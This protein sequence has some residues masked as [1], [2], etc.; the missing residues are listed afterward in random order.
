MRFALWVV[1][2]SMGVV[3]C[4]ESGGPPIQIGIA[5][6]WED[7]EGVRM[8]VDEINAAGGVAHRMIQLE[9][10]DWRQDGVFPPNE[11]IEWAYRFADLPGLVAV[12]GHSDSASTLLSASIYN[13]RQVPQITTIA[14]N[15]A[16]T[17]I[18][19]W[20]FRLCAS[21]RT[22][23]RALAEYAIQGWGKRRIAVIAVDDD[24]GQGLLREFSL[25]VAEL[26]G[27][28]VGRVLHPNEELARS[29]SERERI[30]GV[31]RDLPT[32]ADLLLLIERYP[33]AGQTLRLMAEEGVA[34]DVLGSDSV[35]R[36]IGAGIPSLP[37]GMSVR[38][39][40]FFEPAAESSTTQ[41]FLDSYQA[42]YGYT[43][44]YGQAFAYDAVYLLRDAI[45]AEGATRE[46]VRRF[47]QSSA[48]SGREF[49]GVS[50]TY[51]FG[52]DHDGIRPFWVV[53][54]EPEGSR[55][56]KTIDPAGEPRSA[57][58]AEPM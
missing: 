47:L 42:R 39:I 15:P 4:G 34:L 23:A 35:T 24:Y 1:A 54:L 32:R 2:V 21:D 13:Q 44:T 14:T 50:G 25:Q 27:A 6:S 8:A 26:G 30:R 3:G 33:D 29:D 56:V 17:G 12:I 49:E 46:A 58:T 53:E 48:E 40:S 41:A 28:V 57:P 37:D 36:L 45:R 11:V 7:H 43:P 31:I 9:G 51:R 18:G 52:L 38:S 19:D 55:I 5:L 20:T 22:Q 10:D 16:I